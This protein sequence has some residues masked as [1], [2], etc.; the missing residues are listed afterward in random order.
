MRFF[1][2]AG[3]LAL[4]L[5]LTVAQEDAGGPDEAVPYTLEEVELQINEYLDHINATDPTSADE[6]PDVAARSL[7]S[8]CSLAVSIIQSDS[9]SCLCS[10]PA[11]GADGYEHLLAGAHPC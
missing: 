1:S 11:Y 8:G 6:D 9:A 4:P 3:L 5:A 7:P 2:L 10:L